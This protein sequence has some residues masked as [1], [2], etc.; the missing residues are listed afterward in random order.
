MEAKGYI[1]T[2]KTRQALRKL[3]DE[4][5]ETNLHRAILRALSDDLKPID[6][7]GRWRPSTLLVLLGC[8]GSALIGV[9]LYFS[10]GG[11]K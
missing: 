1:S 6:A 10:I 3:Y 2:E 4:D 9:F 5:G 11:Q 8:L 7:N